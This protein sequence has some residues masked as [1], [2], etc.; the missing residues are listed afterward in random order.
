MPANS[1]GGKRRIRPCL[2]WVADL[3]WTLQSVRVMLT[4]IEKDSPESKA[5]GRR[6]DK[7]C[8]NPSEVDP[9]HI[10]IDPQCA[11]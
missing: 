3:P 2:L 5:S 9:N 6:T 10:N 7:C 1:H 8:Y 11:T 4:Q